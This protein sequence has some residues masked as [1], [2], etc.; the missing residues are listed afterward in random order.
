M[1]VTHAFPG[2]RRAA[3]IAAMLI[4]CLA[5]ASAQQPTAAA[6]AAAKEVI[7]LKGASTMFNPLIPGVIAQARNMFLQTNPGLNKDL[8]EVAQALRDE[9]AKR[10]DE[11]TNEVTRLYASHFTE[12]ELKELV[13]FYKSPLGKKVISEE[14]KALDKSM[15]FA[16]DWAIKLSEVVIARMRAEMKKKGHEI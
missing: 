5:P 13:T 15:T 8:T 2:A 9:L 12:A 11:V 10:Q 16:Q 3:L 7:A 1:I 4:V 6:L 14:P